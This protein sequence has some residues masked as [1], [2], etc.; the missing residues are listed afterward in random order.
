[1]NTKVHIHLHI[2]AAI[3]INYGHEIHLDQ[4]V[5]LN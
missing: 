2:I 1:M 4:Q 5:L 3:A